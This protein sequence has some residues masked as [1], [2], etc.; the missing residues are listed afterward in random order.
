MQLLLSSTFQ[1]QNMSMRR[2]GGISCYLFIECISKFTHKY[3]PS[4]SITVLYTMYS[5]CRRRQHSVG[6]TAC[7]GLSICKIWVS[8][9]KKFYGTT[10]LPTAMA[11]H[12]AQGLYEKTRSVRLGLGKRKGGIAPGWGGKGQCGKGKESGDREM[13]RGWELKG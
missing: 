4:V 5:H 6:L 9:R 10:Y 13:D 11:L 3:Y 8:A 2:C 1:Q 7:L 12:L